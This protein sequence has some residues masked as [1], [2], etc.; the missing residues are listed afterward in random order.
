[1]QQLYLDGFIK[2]YARKAMYIQDI[3][4][5]PYK[6]EIERGVKVL[7][8]FDDYGAEATVRAFGVGRSTVYVWKQKLKTG[9]GRLSSLAPVSK[10]PRQLRISRDY[11]WHRQEILTL[12][13]QYPGL[14]KDK[15]QVLLNNQSKRVNQQTLSV[16]TVGRIVAKLQQQ[17]QLPTRRQLTLSAR[18]GRLT[19][20]RV[21]R[22]KLKKARRGS[23][24]P[25]QPGD[26]VQVDC[27]IKII[28]GLRRYVISA[29]D[30]RSQFAFSYGYKTLS[31]ASATDFLVKLRQVA[32]FDIQRV[33][34]DNGAEFHKHFHAAT[35]QLGITHFWNYPRSP[36]MNAKIE[37][38]NRTVQEEFVDWHLDDLS[39]D[40]HTLNY[41]LMD[42]LTWYNTKRPHWSLNLKSPMH[43][44]LEVLQLT[45][46]ESRM[47]WTDTGACRSL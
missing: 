12:R 31:S 4:H 10:R 18:T 45:S 28:A 17:G 44:L 6:H 40:I 3:T 20:K 43:Y 47:W 23:F 5:H 1:M 38:Y 24:R 32:P 34:T 11:S 33:Q 2:G 7:L 9:N 25:Q 37:R 46:T 41:K 14:G 42:W 8:F 30:Y 15:L 27:V 21:H 36:K 35:E 16:S 29:V 26:L 39:L 19:D 22:V 13:E